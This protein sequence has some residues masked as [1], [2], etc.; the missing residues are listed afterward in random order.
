MTFADPH[1]SQPFQT[2]MSADLLVMETVAIV[3]NALVTLRLFRFI[4][5]LGK[6]M[7]VARGM[8]WICALLSLHTSAR[9]LQFGTIWMG[10]NSAGFVSRLPLSTAFF[11]L[12]WLPVYVFDIFGTAA[13]K[14]EPA[15]AYFQLTRRIALMAALAF[16][17]TFLLLRFRSMSEGQILFLVAALIANSAM[18]GYVLLR[19]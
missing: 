1:I 13:F 18:T 17:A 7:R 6:R 2:T 9:I 11:I 3:L 14:R 5:A 19:A 15:P 10:E 8:I 12:L 16:T 4:W